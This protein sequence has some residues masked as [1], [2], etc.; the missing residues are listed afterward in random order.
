MF[1]LTD[2]F[3]YFNDKLYLVKK[4]IKESHRPAVDVWKEHLGADIVLRKDEV[5]YFLQVV[6]EL[7]II[8]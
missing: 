4:I 5:L 6:E 8:P 2:Q 1:N 3:V 7:E